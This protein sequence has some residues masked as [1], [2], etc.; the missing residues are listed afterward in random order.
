MLGVIAIVTTI[1]TKTIGT[2][3]NTTN[4]TI[5]TTKGENID[6]TV[7][8]TSGTTCVSACLVI[9]QIEQGQGEFPTIMQIKLQDGFD[10]N[11]NS[12]YRDRSLGD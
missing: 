2:I 12:R 7:G 6:T 3:G 9:G 10:A 4:D 11:K 5:K 1:R 8:A